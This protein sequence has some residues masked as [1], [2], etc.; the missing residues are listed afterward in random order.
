MNTNLNELKY[1][2]T[3]LSHDELCTVNGGGFWGTLGYVIGATA[4]SIYIFA[5]SAADYQA[6][7]P[8]NLKK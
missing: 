5:K 1:E 7:L 2:L 4:K 6:S 8:A 3:A